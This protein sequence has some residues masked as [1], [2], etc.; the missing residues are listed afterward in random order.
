MNLT[1]SVVKLFTTLI[2]VFIAVSLAGCKK[3]LF[4]YRKKYLGDYSFSIHESSS[5]G[6]TS[7]DTSYTN[8]GTITKGSDQ[9]L[10]QIIYSSGKSEEFIL[11]E[12]GSIQLMNCNCYSNTGEF[13]S[14]NQMQYTLEWGHLVFYSSKSVTGT[15][16]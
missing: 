13:E 6:G 9:Q 4:D 3:P 1:G 2:V 14:V 5:G 10:I 7:H 11:F 15:R 16:K 8:D 12:D